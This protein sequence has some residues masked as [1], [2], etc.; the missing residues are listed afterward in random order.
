MIVYLANKSTF[1]NDVFENRIEDRILAEFQ[2]RFR[3]SVGNAELQ[4]WKNSMNYMHRVLADNEIPENTGVA[5]EF[6]IPQTSKRI[7]MILT[8]MDAERRKT[9][10]IV[11]LKQW[12]EAETTEKDAIVSTFL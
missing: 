9:A 8:G 1:L 6:N 2:T 10:V 7:D 3:R 11:E 12:T 5:I 4:S